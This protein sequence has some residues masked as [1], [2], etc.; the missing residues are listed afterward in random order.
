M[1][2]LWSVVCHKNDLKSHLRRHSGVHQK[3]AL[4]WYDQADKFYKC[5]VCDYCCRMKE[6]MLKHIRCHTGEKPYKCEVCNITI[7]QLSALHFHIKKKHPSFKPIK[8]TLCAEAFLVPTHLR[9]HLR[10]HTGQQ[11][12]KARL[13]WRR[14]RRATIRRHLLQFCPLPL[15]PNFSV[16]ST[17]RPLARRRCL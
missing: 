7:T 8:C 17:A 1:H 16:T 5:T 11:A 4:A 13:Q 15:T 3:A 14:P 9:C 2:C 12:Q 6:S 10:S